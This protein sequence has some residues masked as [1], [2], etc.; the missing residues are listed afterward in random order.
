MFRLVEISRAIWRAVPD[1]AAL[2]LG[3]VTAL[4]SA[5]VLLLGLS[6]LYWLTDRRAVATVVSYAL[7]ALG[8]VIAIKATLEWG[9]PPADVRL[10]PLEADPYGFP[11]GHTVA[12][13]VVY[14]GLATVR[15]RLRD[16]W[17]Q[18]G[19]VTVVALVAFSRVALGMHYVGDVL[20]GAVL[21]VVVLFACWRIAGSD[22]LRGFALAT[23]LAVPAVLVTAAGPEAVLALGG[24]VG[25][26]AASYVREGVPTIRNRVEGAVLVVVGV[27]FV[28]GLDSAAEALGTP[29]LSAL[30]YVVLV[31]GILLLP[32]LVARVPLSTV[33]SA[34]S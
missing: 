11:S 25:G 9:R 27:P 34:A 30:V 33:G 32:A 19:V 14:G 29:P 23:V 12:A 21:G 3:V 5:S 28:F 18:A 13:V 2:P 17:V 6:V 7:A 15:D 20:A 10:I 26:T 24:S 4:G 22:P 31:A 8:V 16:R 1:A